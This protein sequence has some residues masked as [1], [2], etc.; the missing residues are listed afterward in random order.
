MIGGK[1]VSV[2]K[3]GD[4]NFVALPLRG[5]GARVFIAVCDFVRALLYSEVEQRLKFLPNR[6]LSDLVSCQV[7]VLR[8][9]LPAPTSDW[10]PYV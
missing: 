6:R 1:R 9:G 7:N 5:S 2:C 3:S 8:T 4:A 10:F